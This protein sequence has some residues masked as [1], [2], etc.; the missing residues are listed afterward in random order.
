MTGKTWTF[1]ELLTNGW[2]PHW[3]PPAPDSPP[4]ALTFT[5][6]RSEITVDSVTGSGATEAE[7]MAEAARHANAWLQEHPHFRPRR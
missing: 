4:Y 5:F 1:E 3:D 2:F 7:A 6:Y